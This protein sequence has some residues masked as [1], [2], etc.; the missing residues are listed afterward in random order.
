[1]EGAVRATEQV[2]PQG[3]VVVALSAR[4]KEQLKQKA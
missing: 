4:T 1:M 3:K 2:K